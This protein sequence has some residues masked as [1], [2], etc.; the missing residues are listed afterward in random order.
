[1][2]MMLMMLMLMLLM[3]MIF[4]AFG[5]GQLLIPSAGIRKLL[6]RG[7]VGRSRLATPKLGSPELLDAALVK[8]EGLLA[9]NFEV[10]G[11][12]IAGKARLL[13]GVPAPLAEAAAAL[14][15]A[16]LARLMGLA[17]VADAELTIRLEG[18]FL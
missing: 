8:V 9:L 16:A 11:T 18:H 1:M 2:V 3:M 13:V 14:L 10:H 6:N 12:S 17:A 4:L 5:H 15:G 7:A